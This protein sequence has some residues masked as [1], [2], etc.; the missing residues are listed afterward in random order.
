MYIA[1]QSH[2]ILTDLS[3]DRVLELFQFMELA[4]RVCYKSEDKIGMVPSTDTSLAQWMVDGKV[5]SCF[6][7]VQKIMNRGHLSV[8]EHVSLTVKFIT[9]RGVTHELVRHR[10]SSYSQE[11]T[12]YCNYEGQDMKFVKPVDFTLTPEDMMCLAAIEDH[13]NRRIRD[14]LTPQQARY[15][16]PNGLKTEIVHTANLREW[17]HILGLRTSVA[18]HPQI[19]GLMMGLLDDL[20]YR[21]P[22]IF[23]DI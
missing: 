19:R 18:A 11:S 12:R 5:P 15:F 22:I 3:V 9:D 10:I 7:F 20:R 1:N 17:C 4:G 2:Q 16:L 23:G 13:Y 21:I 14:G 8:I 6:P